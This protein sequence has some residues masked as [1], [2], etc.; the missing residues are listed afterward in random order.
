MCD[1]GRESYAALYERPRLERPVL[2]GGP[3]RAGPAQDTSGMDTA[4]L[5]DLA[6]DRSAEML[7]GVAKTHGPNALAAIVSARLTVEDL[8]L[9]K[10]VLGDL[11]GVPRLAVPPHEEGEDDHLLLRRDKTANAR[12]A[13]ALGI[14]A[15]SAGRVKEILEDASKGAVRGLVVVGEDPSGLPGF[16]E[17]L[18]DRLDVL[19]AIDWWR[20]PGLERA[21]VALPSCGYGE[22]E[23]TMVN[24][25]G[26]VQRLRAGLTPPGEADPV[27]RI[28]RDLGRRFGLPN[29]YGSPRAIFDDVAAGV[30]AFAGLS[31]RTL[32]DLGAPLASGA[33]RAA[34]ATPVE[35]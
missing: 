1:P 35:A 30:P 2:R 20:S 29:E 26:R 10:R 15:P 8:Y 19:V 33:P 7:R 24:F 5:W 22:F 18:F 17:A 4:S 31:Y 25:Q 32:G 3:G 16:S 9:A 13:E 12:G 11:L 14:G 6:L 21:H 34:G 28:L 27:W 23:G